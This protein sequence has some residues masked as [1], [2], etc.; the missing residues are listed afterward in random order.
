MQFHGQPQPKED[1]L[2]RMER[3]LVLRCVS[4][5]DLRAFLSKV[6]NNQAIRD[7][8]HAATGVDDILMIA[9]KHGFNLS[10]PAVLRAHGEAL[11]QADDA[12]LQRVN[13]WGDALI[14]CFGVTDSD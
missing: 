10:K 11:A 6:G 12:Q 13:T 7:H 8:I 2:F 5:D 3:T 9:E 4:A 1:V 14:H